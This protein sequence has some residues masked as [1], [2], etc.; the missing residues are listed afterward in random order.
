[1]PPQIDEPVDGEHAEAAA[2]GD[3]RQALAG[4]GL[5]PA[6][7][8]GSGEQFVEVENAQQT[9]APESRIVDRVGSGKGAGMRRPP[10]ALPVH[11]G[12]I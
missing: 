3:D 5:L 1:M 12:P 6:E 10:R 11:G 9:G 8:L 2:V 4:E 7:R